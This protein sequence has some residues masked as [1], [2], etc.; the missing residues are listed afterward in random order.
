M[1]QAARDTGSRCNRLLSHPTRGEEA[2]LQEAREYITADNHSPDGYAEDLVRRLLTTIEARVQAEREACAQI[3]DSFV[4]ST[5]A[6]N[7][8]ESPS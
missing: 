2:L 6:L 4:R 1:I 3:A 5:F 8:A 7:E